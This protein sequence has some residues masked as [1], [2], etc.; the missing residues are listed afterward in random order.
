MTEKNNID[1]AINYYLSVMN[2]RAPELFSYFFVKGY[3]CTTLNSVLDEHKNN[4]WHA[5]MYLGMLIT[6]IDDLADNPKCFNPNLLNLLYNDQITEQENLS[7]NDMNL[8]NL[9]NFLFTNMHFHLTKLPNHQDLIGFFKFDLEKIYLSNKFSE[10]LTRNIFT[11]NNYEIQLYGSYT[12]GV[13]AAGMIDLM[14]VENINYNEVGKCREVFITG[15]RLAKIANNIATFAR[16][17]SEGDVTSEIAHAMQAS[18]RDFAYHKH[19]L[20]KEF[21][22]GIGLIKSAQKNLRNFDTVAYARGITKLFDLNMSLI[23]TI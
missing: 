21:A 8:L 4:T 9:K 17:K 16:E 22:H 11:C 12:M 3:R 1:T 20:E 10:L 7:A 23:G 2:Y 14:G 18:N 19:Q 6:L 15:Q 5:K 13:L